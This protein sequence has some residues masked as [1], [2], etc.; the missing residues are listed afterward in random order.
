M[1]KF[2]F[3]NTPKRLVFNISDKKV[4]ISKTS[5]VLHLL[6]ATILQI[7][8]YKFLMENKLMLFCMFFCL[9]LKAI[10]FFYFIVKLFFKNS[11]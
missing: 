6:Y 9:V 11:L 3:T 2:N 8:I 10:S 7:L 4:I 1:E 5:S